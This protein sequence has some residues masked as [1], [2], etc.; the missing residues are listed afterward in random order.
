[1]RTFNLEIH[2]PER[3]FFSGGAES[4]TVNAESGEMGVLYHTLPLVTIL[5]GGVTR[6]KQDGKW[7]EA[8]CGEGF[9]AVTK[10]KTSIFTES[11]FWPHEVDPDAVNGEIDGLDEK[12]RKA[13]SLAEYRMA[14]AQLAI[15]FAKLKIKKRE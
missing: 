12:K 15:Q 9:M 10:E 14:K 11:A 13:A 3:V 2:T 4:L 6:I 7:M 1:M 8:A 5:V